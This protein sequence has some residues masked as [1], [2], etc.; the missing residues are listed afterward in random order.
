VERPSEISALELLLT[1]LAQ[2]LHE[3]TQALDLLAV[4]PA[5]PRGEQPAQRRVGVAVIEEVIGELGE[6]GVDLVLEPGLGTVPAPVVPAPCH[7]RPR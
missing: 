7:P 6:Q 5:E 4:R 3:L 1:P 2:A